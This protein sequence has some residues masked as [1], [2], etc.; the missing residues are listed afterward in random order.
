MLTQ[1][2]RNLFGDGINQVSSVKRYT[3]VTSNGP[4]ILQHNS[5]KQPL[6]RIKPTNGNIVLAFFI[7]NKLI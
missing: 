2:K 3:S 7:P 6:W 1:S 5:G 4:D